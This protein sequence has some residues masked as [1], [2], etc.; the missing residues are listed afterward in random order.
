MPSN[1]ELGRQIFLNYSSELEG[2]ELVTWL[3]FESGDDYLHLLQDDTKLDQHIN[4]VFEYYWELM[5][6]QDK[7]DYVTENRYLLDEEEVIL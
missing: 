1:Y 5:N 4:R 3:G 6:N 7:I 2:V